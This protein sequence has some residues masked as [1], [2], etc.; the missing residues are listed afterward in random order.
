MIRAF[1][2]LRV[3]V[4]IG[5]ALA[6]ILLLLAV[7]GVVSFMSSRTVQG[8][9]NEIQL[10]NKKAILAAQAENEYTGAVL[11]IRR[12]I[13]DG[14]EKYSKNFEIKLETVLGLEKQLL[15]ISDGEQKREIEKLIED[16]SSYKSGAVGELVP[17]LRDQR[18]AK[19]AG[20]SRRASESGEKAADLTRK[21]TPFA[22]S[23]QKSL[24][25]VVDES[26][27]NAVSVVGQ[28]QER[29]EKSIRY[30]ISISV[31]ALILGVFLSLTLTK[32]ITAP[33]QQVI[34]IINLLAEGNYSNRPDTQLLSRSDE[35]GNVAM[36][37]D[38]LIRNT[39]CLLDK[40]QH[41]VGEVSNASDELTAS[42]EQSAQATNQVA[43][44]ITE[45]ASGAAS[46]VNCAEQSSSVAQN[47]SVSVQ[48]ILATAKLAAGTAENT[49]I[50]AV[51]GLKTV[52]TAVNQMVTVEKTVL[53]SAKLV[54]KLGER[55][56]EIGLIVET[57]AGIAG[58]TNLL[59]LNAAIEAARAGEQGRGFA[60]VADEVRKLAEQAQ[61]AAGQIAQLINEIRLETD[62]AVAAMNEGTREVGVGMNVVNT[63]GETFEQIAELIGQVLGQAKE[64][65][66]DIELVANGSQQIVASIYDLTKVSR[67]I[68]CQSENV[69]AAT[70]EQSASIEEI[71]SSSQQLSNMA[72][73]LKSAVNQFKI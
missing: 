65:S 64:I 50:A 1:L 71:A 60:V 11:E 73:D 2:R 41:A 69:S 35:F 4:K 46:Q 12:F 40:V 22:Q 61:G 52:G 48:Q 30:I 13:A 9:I 68:A 47:M 42:S 63:A 29:T 37:L 27:K 23:I 3:G 15:N 36:S 25:K 72:Q 43:A 17:L 45:V 33:I 7:Q 51:G 56:K 8:D 16:T 32:V 38:N 59:A 26:S 19:S 54:I 34:K 67:E 55:S 66:K 49:S 70:E 5:L 31:A 62:Q 20:D 44:S 39:R 24:N 10:S 28:A 53:N 14:D 18:Q 57:I 6:I 21:L 58:Q